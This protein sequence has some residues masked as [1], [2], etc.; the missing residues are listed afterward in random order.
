MHFKLSFQ[1]EISFCFIRWRWWIDLISLSHRD[2]LFNRWHERIGFR[3]TKSSWT[4]AI[5][6]NTPSVCLRKTQGSRRTRPANQSANTASRRDRADSLNDGSCA[7]LTREKAVLSPR[8]KLA[9]VKNANNNNKKKE[10][11]WIKKPQKKKQIIYSIVHY[12][13]HFA[14][15]PT[16]SLHI[17]NIYVHTH[18][19]MHTG[20]LTH[21]RTH[22]LAYIHIRTCTYV[23]TQ[24]HEYMHTNTYI[25]K[26]TKT[27]AYN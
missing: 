8:W 7:L 3:R 15:L 12:S 11:K 14:P 6:I 21:I 23:C 1:V 19:H 16:P 17:K 2:R 9:I 26:R 5:Y 24:A 10:R 27:S 22:M 25:H 20:M 4:L 18:I 13:D